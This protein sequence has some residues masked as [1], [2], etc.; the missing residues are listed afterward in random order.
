MNACLKHQFS[1]LKYLGAS[2]AKIRHPYSARLSELLQLWLHTFRAVVADGIENLA[3]L[4]GICVDA[5]I[6]KTPRYGAYCCPRKR[7]CSE[8]WFRLSSRSDRN[9]SAK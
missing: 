9:R 8:G 3:A 5:D 4:Q 6:C 1:I 7:G 2:S